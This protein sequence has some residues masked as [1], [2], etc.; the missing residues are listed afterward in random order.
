MLEIL[1]AMTP[2]YSGA[3]RIFT[4]SW[5]KFAAAD[6]IT[7][8]PL[9]DEGSWRVN[10]AR[11][12]ALLRQHVLEALDGPMSVLV[13]LDSDTFVRRAL[14]EVVLGGTWIGAVRPSNVNLGVVFFN[15]HQ[16]RR[17]REEFV[18]WWERLH[19][20]V[21]HQ[22]LTSSTYR[23]DQPIWTKHLHDL[24]LDNLVNWLGEEWNFCPNSA[25]DFEK[26]CSQLGDQMAILH[27][28]GKGD[29]DNPRHSAK[30]SAAH[31]YYPELG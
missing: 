23:D 18:D 8:K 9:T 7:I 3:M 22:L 6:T 5:V 30:I 21:T 19:K 24:H 1:T 29:W 12:N 20:D 17:F 10:L 15:L 25:E 26:G 2:G 11:R 28:K 27:V 13:W 14:T 31:K 16:I 4:P